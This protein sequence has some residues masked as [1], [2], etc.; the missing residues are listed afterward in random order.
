MLKTIVSLFV[1]LTLFSI[2]TY[3][4]DYPRQ[5]ASLDFRFYVS[6]VDFS[7]DGSTL[8]GSAK[9]VGGS[10]ESRI[11]LWDVA[12]GQPKTT[13]IEQTDGVESIAFSRDGSTLASGGAD[14]KCVYGMWHRDNSKLFS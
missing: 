3:A 7:S 9:G 1:L 2:S 4:A 12:S 6:S 8:A 5:K 13:L 11:R 10:P 14:K